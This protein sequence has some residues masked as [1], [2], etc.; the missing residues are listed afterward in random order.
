[1][2]L[3]KKE[4]VVIAL[5]GSL[6]IPGQEVD[7]QF[8]KGLRSMLLPILSDRRFVLVIGGGGTAREFQRAAG[9]INFVSDED[10]D[11]L[12]IHA[13]RLNA[14]LLRT[15]FSD[16]AYPEIFDNPNRPIDEDEWNA[17]SLF[18]ASGWRPGC[19]TDY[20]AM[21]LAH[22]FRA[23][24]LIVASTIPYVYTGDIS[25]DSSVKPIEDITW[26]E[27]RSL[28]N[29]TW[30]PG[31]K[32]PVDPVAS[33]FAEKNNIETVVLRGSELHNLRNVIFNKPYKGTRI[34]N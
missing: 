22:R 28:V 29:N 33:R 12:G 17:H 21:Q 7:S 31:M 8:L 13:T 1:M 2:K 3:N 6:I 26:R 10:K 32:A 25:Q 19:S 27:Y 5:G 15:I 20:I 16:V 18:I 24:R 9:E 23:F 4:T 34:H 14:H 11:W 30:S